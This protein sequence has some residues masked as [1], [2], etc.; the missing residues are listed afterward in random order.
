VVHS[1]AFSPKDALQGRVVDVSRDGFLTTMDVS[2]WT[3]IR[4][5][6]LA[7]PLMRKGGTNGHV[8]NLPKPGRAMPISALPINRGSRATISLRKFCEKLLRVLQRHQHSPGQFRSTQRPTS[9]LTLLLLVLC[10]P[11]VRAVWT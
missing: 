6:H 10:L 5:A 3:F 8:T 4:M 9:A 7:E 2:C 11:S 1:I